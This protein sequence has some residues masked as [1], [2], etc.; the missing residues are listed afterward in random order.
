VAWTVAA[1]ADISAL[2]AR[3]EVAVVVLAVGDELG[4]ADEL[5]LGAACAAVSAGLACV[6]KLVGSARV[7]LLVPF[8]DPPLLLIVTP[9]ATS[10]VDP[11]EPAEVD[12]ASDVE[13]DVVPEVDVGAAPV[14]P[15]VVD[16]LG[17]ELLPCEELVADSAEL[18]A[19]DVEEPL[20]DEG[21]ESSAA[22]TP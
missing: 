4:V 10:T 14:V 3:C 17:T 15:V 13:G 9:G 1:G 18:V 21:D 20:V 5:L 6:A 16:G 7:A 11:V 19:D 22:A 12:A 8:A 2:A